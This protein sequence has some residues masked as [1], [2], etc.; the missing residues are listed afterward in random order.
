[1]TAGM[2]VVDF[3]TLELVPFRGKN[4]LLLRPPGQDSGTF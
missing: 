4:Y 2:T 1:M 3:V